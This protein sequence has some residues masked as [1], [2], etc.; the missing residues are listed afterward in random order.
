MR[1]NG[2]I[3]YSI[4]ILWLR[5]SIDQH[6]HTIYPI[7]YDH[8]TVTPFCASIRHLTDCM[9]IEI[10]MTNNNHTNRVTVAW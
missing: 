2:D 8:E 3:S 1:C 6:F 9:L 4:N 10:R 5:H 7:S